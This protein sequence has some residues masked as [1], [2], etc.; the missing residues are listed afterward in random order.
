LNDVVS[1]EGIQESFAED[2]QAREP[3]VNEVKVR[4]MVRRE[5]LLVHK[6]EVLPH[7]IRIVFR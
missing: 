2:V 6:I 7:N 4:K 3:N 1:D 5:G